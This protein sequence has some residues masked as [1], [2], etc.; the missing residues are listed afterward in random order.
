MA[1]AAIQRVGELQEALALCTDRV[2]LAIGVTADSVGQTHMQ[3]GQNAPAFL[4]GVQE[5]INEAYGMSQQAVAE[6]QRYRGG[7]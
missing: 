1:E 2:A 5:R 3:S 6:L 4:A 7:F